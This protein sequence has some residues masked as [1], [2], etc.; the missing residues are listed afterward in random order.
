AVL[1]PGQYSP[2]RDLVAGAGLCAFVVALTATVTTALMT[3]ARSVHPVLGIATEAVLAWTALATGSLLAEAKQVLDALDGQDLSRARTQLARIVG[4]D[5]DTLPESDVAR[6]VIETLA[7][8]ACDGIVAP[9][10]YLVIGG[11][12]AA[13]TYKAVNTLDSMIGHHEAP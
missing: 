4:R 13:L 3:A 2:W 5:T 12:P 10:C 1:K 9:L 7:E 8:S 11:V 6:G